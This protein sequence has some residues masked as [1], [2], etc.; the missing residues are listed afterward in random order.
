ML[1]GPHSLGQKKRQTHFKQ[2]WQ[3]K[4]K[5]QNMPDVQHRGSDCSE[6]GEC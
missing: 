5:I 1:T 2:T 6:E 4:T 3:Y